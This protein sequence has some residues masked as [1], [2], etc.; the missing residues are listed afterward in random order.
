LASASK[1]GNMLSDSKDGRVT[2]QNTAWQYRTCWL[3]IE[4]STSTCITQRIS[5]VLG[6]EAR[7]AGC[8]TDVG[9]DSD[10]QANGIEGVDR[11]DASAENHNWTIVPLGRRKQKIR[12]LALR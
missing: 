1:L 5:R 11:C 9:A 2:L 10:V 8:C 4:G 7:K 3:M 12:K 6:L